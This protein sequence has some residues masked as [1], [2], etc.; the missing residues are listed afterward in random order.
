MKGT[1]FNLATSI[2]FVGYI[3]MQLPSNL[4]ITRVRPG[5]YIGVVMFVWGAISAAQAGSRSFG[6]LVALRFIL[7]FVEVCLAGQRE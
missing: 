2:L 5:S 6:G 3:L 4:L 1:D 7:G